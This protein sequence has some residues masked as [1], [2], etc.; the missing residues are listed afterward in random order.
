M[1]QAPVG[2]GQTMPDGQKSRAVVPVRSVATATLTPVAPVES[3][4]PTAVVLAC[5]VIVPYRN[6]MQFEVS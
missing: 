4:M 1:Q 5:W 3:S 2:C 6:S